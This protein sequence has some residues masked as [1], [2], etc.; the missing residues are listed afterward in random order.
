LIHTGGSGIAADF[1]RL[2]LPHDFEEFAKDRRFRE[3]PATRSGPRI[4]LA[5]LLVEIV[6]ILC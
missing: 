4:V 2:P 3:V 5:V 6:E 1:I